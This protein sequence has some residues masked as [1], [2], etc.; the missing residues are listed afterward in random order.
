MDLIAHTGIFIYP[1]AFCSFLAVFI[2]VER[3]VALRSAVVMPKASVD[4]FV[5]GRVE[6]IAPDSGSVVGRIVASLATRRWMRT[7]SRP[8]P[9]SK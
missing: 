9:A 1:L 4:A 8:M 3:L 2:T 5:S 6:Q 7:R